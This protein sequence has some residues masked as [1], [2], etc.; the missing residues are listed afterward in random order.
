MALGVGHPVA[1]VGFG[2]RS[3]VV[4][5]LACWIATSAQG[6]PARPERAAYGATLPTVLHL[7]DM[8]RSIRLPGGRRVPRPVTTYLWYPRAASEGGPR[9]LVVFG[10][11]FATTP[12]LY[13][14]LLR[15]WAAAGFLVAAPRFPLGNADAPD[16]PN[17]N[18]IVNQPGDLS[19]VISRLL[20][21]KLL[22]GARCTA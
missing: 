3:V 11:G 17:E 19:F 9:P 4:A 10:H 5:A 6:A 21:A 18:D 16:G 13:R 15:A 12:S 22:R 1:V 2:I 7:V 8:S 14:R 20:A